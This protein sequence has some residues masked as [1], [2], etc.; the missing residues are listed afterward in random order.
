MFQELKF[1]ELTQ[2]R[3][4]Q[5]FQEYSRLQIGFPIAIQFCA[6]AR[7]CAQLFWN[8]AHFLGV[9]RTCNC[10]QVK[11]TCAGNPSCNH[12]KLDRRRNFKFMRILLEQLCDLVTP[13]VWIL[14]T[15]MR[16]ANLFNYILDIKNILVFFN[17]QL[18]NSK[19]EV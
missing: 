8:C 13:L 10:A 1:C 6:I 2:R 17:N 7:N 3:I 4:I 12:C 14:C 11:S 19:L 9:Y 5:K 18:F 15:C 16:S